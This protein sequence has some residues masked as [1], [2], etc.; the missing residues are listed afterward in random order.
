LHHNAKEK[1]IDLQ[2]GREPLLLMFSIQSNKGMTIP[3]TQNI[4]LSK[5]QRKFP[6]VPPPIK[7]KIGFIWHSI[8]HNTPDL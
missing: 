8:L 6:K 7:P 2:K 1:S 5:L 3:F 4:N